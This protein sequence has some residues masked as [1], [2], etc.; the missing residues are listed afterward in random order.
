MQPLC[1]VTDGL[2]DDAVAVPTVEDLG[3][4]VGQMR[5]VPKG[6]CGRRRF[7][8]LVAVTLPIVHTGGS[9]ALGR[10]WLHSHRPACSGI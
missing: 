9:A 8:A 6:A 3:S 2:G 4:L 7:S 1:S 5:A 10:L